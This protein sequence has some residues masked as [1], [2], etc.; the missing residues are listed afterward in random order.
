MYILIT[1]EEISI[2]ASFADLASLMYMTL[3]RSFPL[4]LSNDRCGLP[5]VALYVYYVS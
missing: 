5:I 4:A 1:H 2:N 3:C